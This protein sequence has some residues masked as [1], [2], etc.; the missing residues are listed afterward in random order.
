MKAYKLVYGTYDGEGDWC[1]I[2]LTE[3]AVKEAYNKEKAK[4]QDDS[5]FE[6][7]ENK[8]F[9]VDGVSCEWYETKIKEYPKPLIYLASPYSGNEE[10]N[11]QLVAKKASELISQ[12]LIVFCPITMCH[13]MSI[14]GKLP[15]GWEF[16]EKFD[17][18]YLSC[19]NKVIVYR[20]EGWDKSKGVQAEIKIAQEM[21]IPIEYID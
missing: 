14:Y 9:G 10:K 3:E 18:T 12:G 8:S 4:Y 15:G 13:P 19:C 16:W 7:Y 2:F 5:S 6:E 1:E 17:R 21:D 20:I 11:F